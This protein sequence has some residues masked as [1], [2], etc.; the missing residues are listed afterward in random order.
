M[1]RDSARAA[2]ESEPGASTTVR[3]TKPRGLVSLSGGPKMASAVPGKE[4]GRRPQGRG[5]VLRNASHVV[6]NQRDVEIV[7][8]VPLG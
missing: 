2:F 4:R 7:G 6:A 8:T 3:V 5:L 1:R